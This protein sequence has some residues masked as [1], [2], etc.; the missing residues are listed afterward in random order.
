MAKTDYGEIMFD[1]KFIENLPDDKWEALAKIRGVFHEWDETV[2]SMDRETY[3]SE[4]LI[5]YAFMS[6]FLEKNGF[7]GEMLK[8]YDDTKVEQIDGVR[9]FF[10]AGTGKFFK[11]FE[12]GLVEEAQAKF[13]TK[14]GAG[15]AYEFS[16]GDL[17]KVQASINELRDL[18]SASE[19][20]EDNHKS[21]LL[22]RLERLQSELHKKMSDLDRF[23]GFVGDAGVVMGK[24]GKN[25]KPFTDRIKDIMNIVWS[26]Q[27][28]A[29]EMESGV[30]NPFL[31][32]NSDSEE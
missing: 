14:L 1:D 28:R 10:L 23:W 8:F 26:T 21:R 15:F 13:S 19:V 5:A 27:A 18:I 17:S 22:K 7:R 4:Y 11:E 29:E 3:F 20:I 24:F 30:P 31:K 9:E 32:E 2:H 25:A 6:A 12:V 16:E